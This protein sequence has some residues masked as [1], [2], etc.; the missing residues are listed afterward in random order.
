MS[1]NHLLE[2]PVTVDVNSEFLSLF[3]DKLISTTWSMSEFRK[4]K[5]WLA[6]VDQYTFRRQVYIEGPSALY[7]GVYG[8]NFWTAQGGLCSIGAASYS[9]SPM[10]EGVI[11]GR[12]CSIGKGLKF[13]DFAHPSEWA[14]TSIAFFK[15]KGVENLT[16]LH[17]IIDEEIE[18]SKQKYARAEFDPVNGQSYPV[19]SHD[20]W[21]GEGVTLSMGVEI[22]AGAIIAA[23]SVVTKDV[24]PYSVVGGV[25]AKLIKYRFDKD[26]IECLQQSKWWDYNYVD[27]ID[28]P[29]SDP[30][31]FVD[32]LSAKIE[33]L[34]IAPWNPGK[35]TLPNDL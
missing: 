31:Y 3:S 26:V 10:P 30:R 24:A 18:C 11:I 12:Y 35:L 29:I 34:Q 25:P 2:H 28:A 23:G 13:L 9:H 33:R 7:G 8:P 1:D 5:G 32:W 27:F 22:G 17:H 20:V 19:I 14:S 21:I 4:G 16:S 15:P 6:D